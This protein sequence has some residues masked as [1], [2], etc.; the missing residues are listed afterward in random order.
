MTFLQ[1]TDDDARDL[2]IELYFAGDAPDLDSAAALAA[3]MQAVLAQVAEA[4]DADAAR[5]ERR[6]STNVEIGSVPEGQ[7]RPLSRLTP[8]DRDA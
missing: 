3:A 6:I 4:W 7:L 2:A 5:I 8:I 1:L